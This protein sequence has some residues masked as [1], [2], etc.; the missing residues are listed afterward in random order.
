[1]ASHGEE[2]RITGED[3]AREQGAG[4]VDISEREEIVRAEAGMPS[5][6]RGGCAEGMLHAAEP[7]MFGRKKTQVV[8]DVT[9]ITEIFVRQDPDRQCSRYDLARIFRVLFVF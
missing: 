4:S 7:E 3:S 9:R 6:R 1:M 5:L 2:E 8:L